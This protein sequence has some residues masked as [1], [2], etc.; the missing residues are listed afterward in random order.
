MH[1][2][3]LKEKGPCYGECERESGNMYGKYSNTKDSKYNYD[4][5]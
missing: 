4:L 5:P 1:I 2:H 3:V